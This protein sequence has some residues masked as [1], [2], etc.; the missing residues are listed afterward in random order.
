MDHRNERENND[1]AQSH[2]KSKPDAESLCS[3]CESKPAKFR[4]IQCLVEYSFFCADCVSQHNKSRAMRNHEVVP[5]D[6]FVNRVDSSLV[7]T[8]NVKCDKH[9]TKVLDVYCRTCDK[10]MCERCGLFE[11][12]GHLILPIEDQG[13]IDREKLTGL[14]DDAHHKVAGIQEGVD[15]LQG[16]I[17]HLTSTKEIIKAHIKTSIGAII[18]TAKKREEELLLSLQVRF[19]PSVIIII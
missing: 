3:D 18:A 17:L 9:K 1:G 10:V 16:Y 19:H 7:G 4:C 5:L 11:H 15:R 13:V 12:V 6:E 8:T 14:I 2:P